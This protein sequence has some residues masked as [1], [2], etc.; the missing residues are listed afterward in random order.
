LISTD[1][2]SAA[3]HSRKQKNVRK[4]ACCNKYV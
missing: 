3:H 1:I 2:P 4:L